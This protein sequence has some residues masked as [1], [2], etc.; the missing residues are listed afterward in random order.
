MKK[1]LSGFIIIGLLSLVGWGTSSSVKIGE[2]EWMSRN[3]NVD[4]FRNGDIIPEAKT[5]EDWK[6]AGDEKRPAWCYYHNEPSNGEKYGKLYNF[7]ATS[8]PRG[9]APKGWHLPTDSEWAVLTDYLTINEHSGTE[10]KALKSTS[11]WSDKKD[12]TTGNG[13]DDYG[14]N[15]LPGGYRYGFGEFSSI[16]YSV[17]WW[18]SSQYHPNSAWNRGLSNYLDYVYR[19]GI[20]KKDGFYVRCLRD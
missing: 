10:G 7:Y 13:T 17:Y 15:A 19:H 11:G 2:Q 14:W 16:G 3:L 5:N 1:I 8:D 6:K 20:S 4:H 9:L 12:G 18:S